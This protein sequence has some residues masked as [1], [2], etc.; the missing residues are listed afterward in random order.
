MTLVYQYRHLAYILN[1][2]DTEDPPR[3]SVKAEDLKMDRDQLRQ[4]N[5][6]KIQIFNLEMRLN[7]A[8]LKETEGENTMPD[9]TFWQ[10]TLNDYLKSLTPTNMFIGEWE[11][12]LNI[13]LV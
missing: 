10:I 7:L 8:R 2:I 1:V 3:I 13:E 6:E 12:F 5:I 4:L 9:E 11:C